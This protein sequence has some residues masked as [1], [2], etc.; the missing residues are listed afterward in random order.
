MHFSL[1]TM[2]SR[3]CT[4]IVQRYTAHA[5]PCLG[6]GLVVMKVHGATPTGW[7]WKP[8]SWILWILQGQSTQCPARKKEGERMS[9]KLKCLTKGKTNMKKIWNSVEQYFLERSQSSHRSSK[10]S[11]WR[12]WLEDYLTLKPQFSR[13]VDS[14]E[15]DLKRMEK[16]L[17]QAHQSL[18]FRYRLLT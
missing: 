12:G 11:S 2:C 6:V 15:R 14:N 4:N 18:H 9:T 1:T 5:P 17:E 7:A 10:S 13:H 16:D 8:V 3:I